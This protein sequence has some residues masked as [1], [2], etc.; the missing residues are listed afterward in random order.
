LNLVLK[1][2]KLIKNLKNHQIS[3]IIKYFPN[4]ELVTNIYR[5]KPILTT[6]HESNSLS[7]KILKISGNLFV[8]INH[9]LVFQ[10]RLT[11]TVSLVTVIKSRPTYLLNIS[12]LSIHYQ[13][14]HLQISPHYQPFFFLVMHIFRLKTFINIY[15]LSMEMFPL[16]PTVS[17][18]IFFLNCEIHYLGHSGYYL[19]SL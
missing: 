16:D 3:K 15:F 19:E 2:S 1:N 4:A 13:L 18:V 11:S 7:P 8:K 9:P 5:S 10:V 17:Q 14:P 6:L 12:S